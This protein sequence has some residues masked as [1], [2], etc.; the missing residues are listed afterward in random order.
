MSTNELDELKS[1]Y[2]YRPGCVGLL[3][4][5][6]GDGSGKTK[7]F[8]ANIETRTL[9]AFWEVWPE[10]CMQAAEVAGVTGGPIEATGAMIHQALAQGEYTNAKNRAMMASASI[11]LF[12]QIAEQS[13]VIKLHRGDVIL[14]M[15]VNEHDNMFDI[16]TELIDA[17]S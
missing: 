3:L 1:K 11:W 8:F 13:D 14:N 7:G 4:F 6:T 16:K 9:E 17:H 10:I 5:F 15:T 12:S 2:K